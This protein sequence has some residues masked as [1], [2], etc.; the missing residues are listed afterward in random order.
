MA[1]SMGMNVIVCAQKAAPGLEE[2]FGCTYVSQEMLLATSDIVTI[3]TAFTKQNDVDIDA[4]F[5]NMIN[6]YATLI[7][8]SPGIIVDEEA[9]HAKLEACPDFWVGTDVY[10]NE[11]K[12]LISENFINKI[13]N[14]PR[15]YGTHRCA[16]FTQQSEDAIRHE[17]VRLIKHFNKTGYVDKTNWINQAKPKEGL[18]SLQIR[19]L[20]KV[21]IL[22]HC[23]QTFAIAGW[24]VEELE[25]KVFNERQAA[26]ATITI[27]GDLSKA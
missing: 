1:R 2:E 17:T 20:D 8:T 4:D 24:N 25:N 27:D 21:G 13:A 26:V 11:P 22:A 9:L 19:H 5:L 23:F 6:P 14:H 15:V 18:I 3:H 16:G 7:N 12:N 10:N